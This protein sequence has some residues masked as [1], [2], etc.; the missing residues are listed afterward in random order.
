VPLA[1]EDVGRHNAVDKVVGAATRAGVP[2]AE[3]GSS[4]RA[5]MSFEIVQR[6]AACGLT[7]VAGVSAPTSLAVKYAEALGVTVVGFLRGTTMN[8]YTHPQRVAP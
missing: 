7:V 6:A 1:R 4:C 3:R 8:V 2:A 5:A